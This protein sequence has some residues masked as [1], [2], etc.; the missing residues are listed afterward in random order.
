MLM[1]GAKFQTKKPCDLAGLLFFA[2]RPNQPGMI[3]A[4]M[5]SPMLTRIRHSSFP[6]TR[7]IV[8]KTTG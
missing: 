4:R 7:R 5:I 8:D 1:L 2:S 3:N 6:V